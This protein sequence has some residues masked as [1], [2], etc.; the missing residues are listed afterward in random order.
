MNNQ[1]NLYQQSLDFWKRYGETY[2]ENMFAIFEKNLEQSK[3][4][5]DQLQEAAAEVVD[6]QFSLI[7]SGIK[8]L[9]NQTV[10][11]TK[12]MDEILKTETTE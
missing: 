8:T 3:V 4:F 7:I 2:S 1:E 12:S 9:E 6:S 11:L 10:K 5:Q